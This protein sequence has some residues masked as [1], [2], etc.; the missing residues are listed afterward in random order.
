MFG[1]A[2][3]DKLMEHL[4]NVC[5]FNTMRLHNRRANFR[6]SVT[7]ATFQHPARR[8]ILAGGFAVAIA[9]APLV[10]AFA[11]PSAGSSGASVTAC[12]AGESEDLF[13]GEC[14]PEM[15]PNQPGGV[16]YSTPGDSSSLPE[17]NGVPCTG[18]NTGTCIG[19]SEEQVPNVE[20]HS[21]ISS[22]P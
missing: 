7:M 16:S 12:P 15:V 8:I 1:S 20:P 18:A 4:R 10:A 5:P 3:G 2:A 21:S 17:I 6:E 11:V 22:S 19:L 13:T 9:A 14:T